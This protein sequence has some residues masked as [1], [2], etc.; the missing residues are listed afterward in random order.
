MS[1][2]SVSTERKAPMAKMRFGLGLSALRLLLVAV[3]LALWQLAVWAGWMEPAAMSSPVLVARRLYEMFASGMIWPHLVDTLGAAL[4]AL[5]LSAAM[6]LA[7]GM[8]LYRWPLLEATLN[9][10]LV[11]I[12]G[13]PRVAFGPL[14]VLFLGVGITAKVA[15]AVSIALFVF[16]TNVLEGMR[17]IDPMLRRN[18]LL[19]GAGRWQTFAMV[20]GP[21]LVTWMWAAVD[22]AIGL[23]LIGVIICE[24]ISSTSGLGHLISAASMG[25]DTTGV[26]ALLVIIVAAT[27]L[28]RAVLITLR[29]WIAPWSR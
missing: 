7:L 22:L 19:M 5:V 29:S 3:I 2:M 27:V 11:A 17:Q 6:G 21:S 26:V 28:F 4:I 13:I 8:A 12:N 18:F 10:L 14:I 23:C 24:F 9:P 15:L 25:F 16:T 1:V 20:T